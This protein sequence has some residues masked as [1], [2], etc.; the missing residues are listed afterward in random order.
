MFALIFSYTAK[1]TNP[2]CWKGG[3][4]NAGLFDRFFDRSG[5]SLGLKRVYGD[6]D[7]VSDVIKKLSVLCVSMFVR[8][9]WNERNTITRGNRVKVGTDNGLLRVSFDT[10]MDLH[11]A[12]FIAQIA[13]L[14]CNVCR[15][16][17]S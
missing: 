7:N 14:T 3:G 9:A 17:N 10:L 12:V 15:S 13:R 6:K 5:H 1:I 11:Q 2:N 16:G 4:R 8:P